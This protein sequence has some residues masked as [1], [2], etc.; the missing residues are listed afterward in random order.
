MS[1][2]GPYA[3]RAQQFQL[4]RM[5][6]SSEKRGVPA[7]GRT[8]RYFAA[9]VDLPTSRMYSETVVKR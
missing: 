4:S 5:E 3:D 1:D 6:F 8:P 7:A 9:M 2:H